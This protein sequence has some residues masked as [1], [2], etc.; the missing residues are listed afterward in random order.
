MRWV[1]PGLGCFGE[2]GEAKL[3]LHTMVKGM[4]RMNEIS[5]NAARDQLDVEKHFKE[6]SDVH[7]EMFRAT[8]SRRASWNTRSRKT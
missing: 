1:P 6:L 8:G 3:N 7:V 4:S 2:V 5:E